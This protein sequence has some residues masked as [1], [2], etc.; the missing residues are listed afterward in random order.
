MPSR[1][2]RAEYFMGIAH[3]VSARSTCKRAKVGAVLVDPFERCIAAT[4]YNGSM[5][6]AKHCTE[7]GCI[8]DI[9]GEHCRRAIHAE[10]NA[11]LH[12][13]SS[14]SALWLYSTH[15]PCADCLKALVSVRVSMITYESHY[16]DLLR[17]QFALEVP[18]VQWRYFKK[19]DEPGSSTE[20][21]S[22]AG[23]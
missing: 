18:H 8:L 13:R 10:L 6:E 7:E 2:T 22:D 21:S 11:V 4:G 17:D 15:Q 9:K 23:G 1:L 14:H 5:P 16:P 12:L 20:E 3:L 19:G